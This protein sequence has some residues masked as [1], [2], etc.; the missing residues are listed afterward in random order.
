MSLPDVL[1]YSSETQFRTQVIAALNA[2]ASGSA[3]ADNS[4]ALSKIVQIADKKLLGNRSGGTANVS[5][6]DDVGKWGA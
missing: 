4:I 1:I 6:V 5:A 3:I 2:L